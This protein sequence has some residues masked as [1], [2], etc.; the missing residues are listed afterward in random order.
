MVR[1]RVEWFARKRNLGTVITPEMVDGK[2]AA[3]GEVSQQIEARG[4][5]MPWTD[6]ARARLERIPASVRGEVMQAVEGNARAA[7]A[8]VVDDAHLDAMRE[9]WVRSGDF[10][11]GRFGFKA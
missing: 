4:A 9:Q 6:A 10:H 8:E 5:Q 1:W 7:G 2:V 3:W 11:Q